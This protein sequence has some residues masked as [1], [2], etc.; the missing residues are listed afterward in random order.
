MTCVIRV[1]LALRGAI[2]VS[3]DNEPPAAHVYLD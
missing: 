3:L 2:T 1:N